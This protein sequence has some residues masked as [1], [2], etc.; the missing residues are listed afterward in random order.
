MSFDKAAYYRAYH[1]KNKEKIKACR[2]A[3]DK[4]HKEEIK[5]RQDA[6]NNTYYQKNFLQII[7]RQIIQRCTNPKRKDYKNYGGR[8]IKVL[9]KDFDEFIKDVGERPTPKHSIDRIFNDGNY[10]PGNCKWSTAKEQ[11]D[12][13]R[14][15]STAAKRNISESKKGE[16]N[17]MYGKHHTEATKQKMRDAWKLRKIR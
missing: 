8:G 14:K 3:Y 12:N 11:A 1:Q 7:W 10:E 17:F 15:F 13:R 5:V 16:K 9:Y 6:Y 2:K 4:D